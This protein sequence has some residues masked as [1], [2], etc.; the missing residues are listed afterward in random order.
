MSRSLSELPLAPVSGPPT[1]W[2]AA[3]VPVLAGLA[4][5][6]G[7]VYGQ[8]AA[9]LWQT[10]EHA[11]GPLIA[12]VA[13]VLFWRLRRPLAALPDAWSPGLGGAGL[14][15]GL[16]LAVVGRSQDVH[17]L[18][19][20]SQPLVLGGAIAL[21]R[22]PTGLRLAWFPLLFLLFMVPLP[23]IVI[24]AITSQL[25]SWISM[26][27][28]EI[29]YQAGYPVARSGVVITIGQY[30]LLVADACSGLH[31]MLS[32]SALGSLF[33]WLMQPR[34]AWHTAVLLASLL[35]VAF[36]ANLARVLALVLV[37]F[38]HGDSFARAWHDGLGLSVFG[39]ALALLVA[40][41]AALVGL[42][43]RGRR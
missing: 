32:L 11:H 7:P 22:G 19:L 42:A 9:S 37:T 18:T 21:L 12:V 31:S 3:L 28:E 13:A 15:A 6:Y 35:P 39:T 2:T 25:K 10:D 14:A 4:I 33:V 5:L 20:A 17:L 30:Q 8:L 1:D 36:V 38:H 29:L 23:G 26:A 24:D 43:A 27:A 40:L 41:D 16:V 34:P